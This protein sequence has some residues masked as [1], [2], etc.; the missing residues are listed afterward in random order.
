MKWRVTE[1]QKDGVDGH[2]VD[3]EKDAGDEPG[4]DDQRNDRYEVVV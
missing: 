1:T 4:S 2:G 3:A